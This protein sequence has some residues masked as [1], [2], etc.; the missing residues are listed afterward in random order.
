[1][2]KNLTIIITFF[3]GLMVFAYPHIAQFVNNELQKSQVY[4]FQRTERSDEEVD[5]LVTKATECNKQIYY[6]SKEFRDPFVDDDKKPQQI[7]DCM[8]L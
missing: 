8:E 2:K 6:D 7:K 3:V 5:D 1:M 4:D